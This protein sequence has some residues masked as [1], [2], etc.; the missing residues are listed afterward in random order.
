[1]ED[2]LTRKSEVILVEVGELE[3][4]LLR[5]NLTNIVYVLDKNAYDRDGHRWFFSS[6][7]TK[8]IWLQT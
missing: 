2:D 1:M 4:Y 8:D 7:S 6:K 5:P 3:T